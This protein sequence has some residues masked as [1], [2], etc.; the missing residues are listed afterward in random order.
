[1]NLKHLLVVIATVGVLSTP[2]RSA[3]TTDNVTNSLKTITLD[4][5][6]SKHV[7]LSIEKKHMSHIK[8]G[9]GQLFLLFEQ[10]GIDSVGFTVGGSPD[11][12]ADDN[13]A[14]VPVVSGKTLLGPISLVAIG[15]GSPIWKSILKSKSVY[16]QVLSLGGNTT[17]AI[18]FYE[19]GE[20]YLTLSERY[21]AITEGLDS[22]KFSVDAHKISGNHQ[23]K[24]LVDSSAKKNSS[25]I[26]AYGWK[27]SKKEEKFDLMKYDK[28]KIGYVMD[29]SDKLYC[30]AKECDYHFQIDM[31]SINKLEVYMGEHADIENLGQ[32]GHTVSWI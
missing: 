14:E 10:R 27:G 28:D 19:A 13:G 18:S 2:V 5:K 20:A 15:P 16:I 11:A 9:A 8:N 7:E 4:V 29:S 32:N 17:T 1:M 23:I 26:K 6:E 22:I 12:F 25:S 30:D 31:S 21:Q 24:F 3:W